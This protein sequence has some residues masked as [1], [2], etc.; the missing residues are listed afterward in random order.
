MQ[1]DK[2]E[3]KEKIGSLLVAA[4]KRVKMTQQE[5][6]D[7]IGVSRSTVA[8]WESGSRS[9]EFED[10]PVIADA[11]N[12]EPKY[13]LGYIAGYNDG[14]SHLENFIDE[15]QAKLLLMPEKERK[16][17]SSTV[18][19]LMN[20]HFTYEQLQFIHDFVSGLSSFT[21]KENANGN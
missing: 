7:K 6:A 21:Q 9:F 15:L 19:L 10:I 4:R 8:N 13:F 11:L 14:S 18:K 17:T 12:I 1:I 16:V 5:F 3:I 20:G 2:K